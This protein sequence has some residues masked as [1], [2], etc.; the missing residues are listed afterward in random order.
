MKSFQ[1]TMLTISVAVA[2]LF[3]AILLL[4]TISTAAA[5]DLL[6]ELPSFYV[7]MEEYLKTWLTLYTVLGFIFSCI[8][9]VLVC[10]ALARK[11]HLL[12]MSCVLLV[13]LTLG[14]IFLIVTLAIG[15]EV[16][17]LN[18]FIYFMQLLFY[19]VAVVFFICALCIKRNKSKTNDAADSL[20][21]S[22]IIEFKKLKSLVDSGTI[23][24]AE[25]ESIKARLFEE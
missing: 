1:K 21:E 24:K 23:T 5:I 25:Y 9:I 19:V 12:A 16:G 7:T 13:P 3:A 6:E 18:A 20:S 17:F 8:I 11:E 10:V 14:L 22:F 4:D 15:G 2:L